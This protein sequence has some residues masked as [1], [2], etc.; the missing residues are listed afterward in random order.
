MGLSDFF[1]GVCDFVNY[2]K[3][4]I[5]F[6]YIIGYVNRVWFVEPASLVDDDI[7]CRVKK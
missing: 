3:V 7:T 5:V 1:L 6:L 2:D 4:G